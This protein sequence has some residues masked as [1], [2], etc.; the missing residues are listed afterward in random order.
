MFIIART[1]DLQG[2]VSQ[3]SVRYVST[4]APKHL[5]LFCLQY[6]SLVRHHAPRIP[7]MAASYAKRIARSEETG[8]DSLRIDAG[9]GLLMKGGILNV[10]P[11]RIQGSV[12]RREGENERK[13]AAVCQGRSGLAWSVWQA[14][15]VNMRGGAT[16]GECCGRQLR[17]TSQRQLPADAEHRDACR[18]V[19]ARPRRYGEMQLFDICATLLQVHIEASRKSLSPSQNR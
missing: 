11:L 4:Q 1:A 16:L 5:Y 13:A 8:G 15:E 9:S 19:R 14:A 3:V 10:F 7:V 18:H 2:G 17:H 12:R 6:P